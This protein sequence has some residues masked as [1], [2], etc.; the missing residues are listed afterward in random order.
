LK[1]AGSGGAKLSRADQIQRA[2]NAERETVIS[3]GDQVNSASPDFGWIIQPDEP[4]DEAG[5]YRQ[6]PSQTSLAALIS[7]PAWWEEVGLKVKRSWVDESKTAGVQAS[8]GSD[9]LPDLQFTIELP[10]NFETVDAILFETIDRNP[11]IFESAGASLTVKPCNTA[12]IVI[13]GRRLWRS[14]VV[15]LGGQKA[16]EIFVLPDM[17]GIIAKF[18][19]V[20]LP[21]RSSDPASATSA[22]PAPATSA[23]LTAATSTNPTSAT[24]T[25]PVA[26]TS[27]NPASASTSPV[28]ATST[29][30]VAATSTPPL[31]HEPLTVWTSQGSATLPVPVTFE[32]SDVKG[33]ACPEPSPATAVALPR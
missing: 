13:P 14:T 26:A 5:S 15:T 8:A 9:N 17:N 31:H 18:N 6:R 7:L 10:V 27:A 2:R 4:L 16:D 24:S 21:S 28:A 33:P 20:H 29:N 32:P 19:Q 30:P 23:N 11:V 22:N 12:E 3:F 25:N 1:T